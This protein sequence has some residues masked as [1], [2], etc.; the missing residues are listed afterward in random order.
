[1]FNE[2]IKHLKTRAVEGRTT[3]HCQSEWR[4]ESHHA[5]P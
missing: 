3:E 1:V 4:K 2:A 5:N